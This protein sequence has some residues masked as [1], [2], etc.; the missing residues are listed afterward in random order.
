[1]QPNAISPTL[2]VGGQITAAEV[3]EL[4]GL[5]FRSVL[6]NRPD[7]EEPGQPDFAGI[8]AAARAAG[9]EVRY[10]PISGAPSDEAAADFGKAMDALPKPVFAYCR[11]GMRSATAWALSQ[12][13]VRSV[14]DILA[15]T[16]AAGYDIGAV[17]P[18]IAEAGRVPAGRAGAV[19]AMA[20]PCA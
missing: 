6:C 2:S 5:G 14:A 8:A 9:L 4:A 20:S 1:M 3:R 13:T 17:V 11:S 16:G 18:R 10:Q 15:A 12:A 7:G 19:R